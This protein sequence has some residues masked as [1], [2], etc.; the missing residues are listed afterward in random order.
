MRYIKQILTAL[1]IGK[2]CKINPLVDLR[3]CALYFPR[4]CLGKY[5]SPRSSSHLGELFCTISLMSS[6][7]L[8][9]TTS[10]DIKYYAYIPNIWREGKKFLYKMD[11]S[12]VLRDIVVFYWYCPCLLWLC[13]WPWRLLVLVFTDSAQNYWYKL[14]QIENLG[15]KVVSDND[16]EILL[17][18]WWWCEHQ[19]IGHIRC[20][21]QF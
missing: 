3:P 15:F 5:S 11:I 17:G 7:Y 20:H 21:S 10:C 13:D 14:Y 18:Q 6:Q 2:L 8:Y 9:N 1:L 4:L 16:L 12:L 19:C